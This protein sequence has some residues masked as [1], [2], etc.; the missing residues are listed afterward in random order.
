MSSQKTI[1]VYKRE[2]RRGW[3]YSFTAP[4]GQRIRQAAGTDDKKQANELA[5]KHYYEMFE[6]Q[7]L[8][9]SREYTWRECVVEWL[10]ENPHKQEDKT[11]LSYLRWLDDFLGM[12]TLNQIG[13]VNI[14]EIRD[15]KLNQGRKPRTVNAYLNQVKTVLLA[16]NKWGWL[17]KV[18]DIEMLKEPEPRERWLTAMEKE[19]LFKELPEHLKPIV[20]FALA[21]GLRRANV[22]GLKW[23]QIDLSRRIAWIFATQAKSSKPIGIP[24]NDEA[25][26][27]ILSQRGKHK[28]NVFTYNGKPIKNPAG[29]AWKKALK[30]AKIENYTFHDN[31]H[32][33]ATN[34][35]VQG[36]PTRQL[37]ELG[38]W[39][40]EKMVKRY[41]HMNVEHLKQYAAN[42][43][44][45][46]TKLTPAKLQ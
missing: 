3:Y 8:G 10:K 20:T 14:R 17:P 31:R 38:G 23:S 30:R 9:H 11:T 1:R 21:T 7:K 18:P 12:L 34:H 25:M 24:L 16:A 26:S 46:D 32:T 13:R 45:F 29:T 2:G 35:A 5:A 43:A 33:W 27:A 39:S 4:N 22:A 44:Q 28:T 37:T 41:A 40:S 6:V 42:S 19:R 36:T 15:A